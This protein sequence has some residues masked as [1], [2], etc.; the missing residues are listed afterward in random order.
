MCSIE[1]AWAGQLFEN[2]PVSSQADLRRKYMSLPNEAL[3]YHN[4]EF[5]VAKR[6]PTPR[7]QGLN[8]QNLNL[9]QDNI[10]PNYGGEFPRPKY[11]S[12][13]DNAEMSATT[14]SNA[15]P[16]PTNL[17]SRDNFND[18]NDAFNVSDTVNNFMNSGMRMYN[19]AN[20]NANNSVLLD[21]DSDEERNILQRKLNKQKNNNTISDDHENI[22][23]SLLDIVNRLERMEKEMHK[24]NSKNM[25]DMILYVL[26]GL[27]IIL[28]IN[29]LLRK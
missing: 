8:T 18:I 11:M 20:G 15:I 14:M 29:S 1:E 22:K 21:E 26:V 4:N 23:M 24:N 7:T 13:Y 27:L 17:A 16:M 6:T 12:I 28:V 10:P 3:N 2:K 19:N 25:H 9:P 5:T